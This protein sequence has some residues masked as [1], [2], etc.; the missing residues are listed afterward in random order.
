MGATL[1]RRQRQSKSKAVRC[2]GKNIPNFVSK[3]VS[4]LTVSKGVSKLTV[5]KGGSH[6]G[7][8][9]KHTRGVASEM[10]KKMGYREGMGLGKTLQGEILI[11]CSLYKCLIT[12]FFIFVDGTFRFRNKFMVTRKA[13]G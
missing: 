2:E 4:K 13:W 12:W 3:G 9:E 10:M 8:W 7:S 1:P 5:S 6:I 11:F